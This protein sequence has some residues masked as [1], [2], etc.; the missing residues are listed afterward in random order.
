MAAGDRRSRTTCSTPRVYLG[1]CDKIVPGLLIARADLRPPAGGL[2]SGR[3]DDH[4]HAQRREGEGPPALC[5]GQGRPRRT[6]GSR[7]RKS[8][9]GPGTCTFYGTANSNQM[10]MEIMGL[11]MPGASLRQS[12]HAAAR[13]A[14]PRGGQA[15]AGDH[16]AGQRIHA[17]RRD[18]STRSAIVNGVVG[19]HATGGSTNHTM[20]LVAMARAAGIMLTWEDISEL[21]DVVPLLARVYPNGLADVNHFHAAGGMGFLIRELLDAGL[22]HDDVAHRRAATGLTAYTVEAEAR[23]RWR[24]RLRA[25][26]R[27]RA[28]TRRCWRRS[29]TPFQ[30]TGGL[31][32]LHGN[33][34]TGGD[35]DLRRQAGAPRRSRRRPSSS[36]TSRKAAA[37]PSRPA[38]STGDFI[39][40]VRFQGPKANGMPELHKLTPAARRA[41]GPR[42]QAWRSSPTGACPAPRARCR[43]R[44]T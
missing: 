12:R 8:Y 21:S 35:Q 6:A 23:R 2:H 33:L 27:S 44:S 41:A 29:T 36:T 28:A 7:D 37:T 20:H 14:D 9:H 30:P 3:A 38:S 43:R 24:R 16:R 22:L 1:V 25:G 32:M 39:A 26:R 5:R 15:G 17:G 19:L 40:V 13:S 18:R 34:G 10:L 42:L 11:H 31:K 4:R